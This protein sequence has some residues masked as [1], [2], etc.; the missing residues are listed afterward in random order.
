MVT[1]IQVKTHE[2][3]TFENLCAQYS[4]E[5]TDV[6]RAKANGK[7]MPFYYVEILFTNPLCLFELGRALEREHPSLTFS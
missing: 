7:P 6:E 5:I 1:T 3:A 2:R 4:I